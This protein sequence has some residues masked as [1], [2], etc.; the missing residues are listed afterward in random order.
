MTGRAADH[1]SF[2]R[3]ATERQQALLRTALLV[4]GDRHRAEDLRWADADTLFLS[5][6]SGGGRLVALDG[7]REGRA[8]IFDVVRPGVDLGRAMLAGPWRSSSSG[9]VAQTYDGERGTVPGPGGTGADQTYVVVRGSGGTRIL[10]LAPTD[11]PGW[12]LLADWLA[13]E[14]LAF[15][16]VDQD[17]A[18]VVAWPLGLADFSLVTTVTGLEPTGHRLIGG[19]SWAVVGVLRPAVTPRA[20]L[21]EVGVRVDA[22]EAV[23]DVRAHRSSVPNNALTRGADSHSG[24]DRCW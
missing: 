14:T 17:T 7:T 16:V 11:E 18:R 1:E 15:E 24:G 4:Y 19:M 22:R 3:W 8:N 5:R 21:G 9:E 6:A 12:A 23:V 10:A 2:T 13:P 20:R